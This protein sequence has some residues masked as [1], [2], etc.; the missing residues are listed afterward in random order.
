[1]STPDTDQTDAQRS[2]FIPETPAGTQLAHLESNTEKEAWERLLADASHMPYE[3]IEGFKHRG[4]Q[5]FEY[6]HTDSTE[7]E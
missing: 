5:V 2:T 7:D 1:M 3:G 6:L 4:Y